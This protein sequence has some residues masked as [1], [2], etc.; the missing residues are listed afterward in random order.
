MI[1]MKKRG[2]IEAQF[3][4]IFILFIGAVIFIFFM[5]FSS[6]QKKVADDQISI[7][8]LNHLDSVAKGAALSIGTIYNIS[9]PYDRELE[10]ICEP[11][12][13]SSLKFK[14]SISSGVDITYTPLFSKAIIEGDILYTYSQYWMAP[15]VVTP[16]LYMAGDKTFFLVVNNPDVDQ[17]LIN[18]FF[19][20]IPV[21]EKVSD[22]S[23]NVL[24][25]IMDQDD[26]DFQNLVFDFYSDFNI[27]YFG[28]YDSDDFDNHNFNSRTT[29]V[30]IY[31]MSQEN[32]YDYDFTV[33]VYT[34]DSLSSPKETTYG[35]GFPTLLAL[36]FSE[37]VDDY[38]CGMRKAFLRY[39]VVSTI[40]NDKKNMTLEFV[41]ENQ[42]NGTGRFHPS[43]SMYYHPLYFEDL[44]TKSEELFN[45]G[46]VQ[47]L[48]EI[49][50]PA[51]TLND[52]NERLGDLSCPLPY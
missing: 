43:C 11:E 17:S 6:N 30:K 50:T 3:N 44:I 20:M 27:I 31:N 34:L 25:A 15:Y 24:K 14:D 46:D 42:R 41:L 5:T 45:S 36:V 13:A 16:L 4:W 19:D 40:I 28:N 38:I 8:L 51:K 32:D 12:T 48:E 26:I 7:E 49:A 10:K 1:K 47:E 23:L 37:D 18:E 52:N 21:P 9:L 2:V 33:D 35:F 22:N 29:K 39:K